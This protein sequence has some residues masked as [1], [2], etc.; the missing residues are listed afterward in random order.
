MQKHFTRLGLGGGGIKGILHVGALQELAKYQKLEFP[1]GVYGASIGSIIGTYV[2]FGLPIDKLS[3]LTKKHL[4]TKNFTPSIGL[5]DIT[6]CLSKK[7]LFSMNQFEKTVCSV[8]DEAGLDIRKKVIGDANMPLFI[9]ASNVTKG[10]PTIFSKDV[11]LLEAIKCSC[12]IPGVFKPQVL[13][14]QVYV[15]GDLFTPN[16]GVIVPISDDTIIL[17]LPRRRTIVIT[18]ETIDSVSPFDFA[19]DLISIATRQS[20]LH[21]NN[22]CTLPLMYPMLTSSSD[23]EKMDIIDIF[24]YASSKL[25]RFLLTKNLC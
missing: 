2:A 15:D 21:K 17:T 24:K 12:C 14:N 3:D 9:I 11:P 13:Y 1:N 6:S 4:S 22:P 19:Y 18:A 20:G 25:R 5:Y 7:G 10:K 8:F 23:L 16:I